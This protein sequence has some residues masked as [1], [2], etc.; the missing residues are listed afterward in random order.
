MSTIFDKIRNLYTVDTYYSKYGGSVIFAFFI[1]VI[2][3]SLISYFT[4]QSQL[5]K[6]RMENAE[7]NLDK[8]SPLN[9]PIYGN[10]LNAQPAPGQSQY[11][12]N[13]EETAN[14]LNQCTNKFLS[15]LMDVLMQPI[16]VTLGI[17]V[18]KY[19]CYEVI[20]Q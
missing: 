4:M 3:V 19:R 20:Y 1:V 8:C 2:V 18:G 6:L 10:I 7:G 9:I 12:K 5:F 14:N 16:Y 17:I 11:S 13:Y 15:E